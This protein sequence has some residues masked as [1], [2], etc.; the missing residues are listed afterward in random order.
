MD[1]GVVCRRHADMTGQFRQG[2]CCR[3]YCFVVVGAYFASYFYS[4]TD[5]KTSNPR[6]PGQPLGVAN[7]A[8][9]KAFCVRLM[10]LLGYK[11]VPIGERWILSPPH[12]MSACIPCL[13]SWAIHPLPWSQA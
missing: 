10:R 8:I 2:R 7:M 6:C 3:L 12:M 5:T 9:L 4:T 1:E 11:P 13:Y